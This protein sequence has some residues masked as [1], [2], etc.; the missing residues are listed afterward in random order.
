MI[1]L[2][3]WTLKLE[4]SFILSLLSTAMTILSFRN[5]VR[6]VE[7]SQE[8]LLLA[9]PYSMAM[10]EQYCNKLQGVYERW[11][12]MLMSLYRS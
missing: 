12:S 6:I 11:S 2:H 7:G 10:Y 3:R 1:R 5:N 8:V 9:D 4:I